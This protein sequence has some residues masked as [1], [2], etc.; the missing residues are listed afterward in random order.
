MRVTNALTLDDHDIR[1]RFVRACGPRGQNVRK[2]ATA[3]EL[4]VDL[5][6]LSLP[7]SVLDRLLTIAARTVTSKNVLVVVSRAHRSQAANRSAAR[8]RL[9]TLL[10]RAATIPVPRRP[11]KARQQFRDERLSAKRIHGA[12]KQARGRVSRAAGDL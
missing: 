9:L 3:V 1:E 8:E 12:L 11:A 10:R 5:N 2:E 4:R 7:T 6:A